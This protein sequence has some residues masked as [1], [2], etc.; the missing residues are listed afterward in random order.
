MLYG[1]KSE[2]RPH[3]TGS[4]LIEDEK[5]RKIKRNIIYARLTK[6]DHIVTVDQGT[7]NFIIRDA[8][9]DEILRNLKGKEEKPYGKIQ[10]KIRI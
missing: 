2:R 4:G 9:S 7:N 6:D 1:K 5:K 8:N 3:L 10:F